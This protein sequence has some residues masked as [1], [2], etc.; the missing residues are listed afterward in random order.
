[1][2]NDIQKALTPT[3]DDLL[4]DTRLGR[5]FSKTNRHCALQ[6]WI[7][8]LKSGQSIENR[9]IYGRLLPYSYSNNRWSA[10]DDD[11]FQTYDQVRAQVI[12]L[13]LYIQSTI[14]P[15]LLRL[16]SAGR[17]IS[18]ISEELKLGLT[19]KL[20][21]RFGMTSLN[22]ERLVYRP[23]AY[24]LNRDAHEQHS[25][26]SPHGG[27]GVFSASITQVDKGALFHLGHGY[28]S[29][30]TDAVIKHLN[31]CTGL[32]FS[33]A[34]LT[35]LGDI[36][37][38]VFPALDDLERSL[39]SVSW[40][41]DSSAFVARFNPQQV[42]EFC[43]FQFR[44]SITN[45]DQ[46]AYAE[47]A[48][49]GRDDDGVFECR[50]EIGEQLRAR[51]DATELE[52]FGYESK[53]S[54]HSTLCC[55]WRMGYVREIN[56]QGRAVGQGG[57][58]VKFDWLEKTT[59]PTAAAR[60]RAVLTMH[61]DN[62]DFASCIGGRGADP[63][64]RVNQDF[65][66]IFKRLHPPKSEGQFFQRWGVGEGD[67][68][69]QF[70]EWFRSLLSKYGQHQIV[71]FDPYFEDAGL[72]LLLLG[73]MPDADYIVFTSLP[74][75]SEN[76]E[77]RCE[78]VDRPTSGRINNLLASC[79]RN[80]HL[81]KRTKLRVYGM[82][83][84]RLHD[85]Y[86]LVMAPDG[87]PVAGFNL[88][89]S[90]QSAAQNYPL[91]ITPI[92]A[93]TLLK[94]EHYVAELLKDADAE[95]LE[96][97]A[98]TTPLQ[99][100]FDAS[101]SAI[102]P[103]RHE[104]LQFLEKAQSG[105]VLAGWVCAPSLRT[106]CGDSLKEKMAALGL[107]K[108]ESLSLPEARSLRD[109]LAQQAGDFTDFLSTWEILG[110]L[111]A[112]TPSGDQ[113]FPELR[114]DRGFLEFLVLYLKAS[115]SRAYD[116]AD[117]ELAVMSPQIF[118]MSLDALLHSSY[119]TDQLFHATKYVALTWADYFAIRFLWW[120]DPSALLLLAE[121]QM[122]SVPQ[123]LQ[124][125][126][127][128][129]LSLLGQVIAEVSLAIEFGID[130][131]QRDSL[132]RSKNNLLQWMGLCAIERALK[133]SGDINAAVELIAVFPCS[134]HISV[135]GWMIHRTAENPKTA[136][137]FHGL[138]ASLHRSLPTPIPRAEL[139]NT[140]YAMRGHMHQLGWAGPW[141]FLDVV[142]PLLQNGRVTADD[143]CEIWFQELSELL[144]PEFS[145]QLHQFD[146][147][148]EGQTTN[149]TA[150]LFAY[151]G[152][153][154]QLASL[155]S[156]KAIL[157]RQQRIVQQPLA[158][159]TD[160]SRWDDAL[161]VSLWTLTFIRWSQ[162]YLADGS[163]VRHELDALSRDAEK[164]VAFRSMDEWRSQRVG[165]QSELV[166]FLDQAEELLKGPLE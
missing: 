121:E 160:W 75:P 161:I 57:A 113:N 83:N 29:A 56:I 58:A 126:D 148:R 14:C 124:A 115:F 155:A 165:R 69:L 132:V 4:G 60:L 71:I 110:D 64:V 40:A 8:Q 73:G 65:S 16:L 21:A 137:I 146:R 12:Q 93:D 43:G 141:L 38:M 18:A 162:H 102:V 53:Q 31:S 136:E 114:S 41:N 143:A 99:L 32:D 134:A 130:D 87:L 135:L 66:T 158:S 128:V 45:G 82:K 74:K 55:R 164:L 27:A 122:S 6:F 67:G 91:L 142:L 107:L 19:K 89:N 39:M 138:I 123:E 47:I 98:D 44:L 94:V 112:H 36:E 90:F 78:G 5:L 100:L 35:R 125:V 145:Q 20:D 116:A 48:I 129:R 68:R 154:R 85:R 37:L 25:L 105:D 79:E 147:S 76:N 156:L 150:F 157:K 95:Q 33:G 46:I 101:A 153:E 106:L 117:N 50:F 63:W 24:L 151:S 30:L 70:V 88:S 17:T 54:N 166:V 97:E 51:V 34:D 52:I 2:R 163:A 149:T 152:I 84:G 11:V 59:R 61:R 26:S 139:R 120:Y 133:Q 62:L 140:I 92:P 1:M 104:P 42:P 103:R 22:A 3:L 127:A 81:M 86:I 109:F 159:T 15:K 119:R 77:P 131:E 7:L 23:V 72:G 13:N 108:G 49:A 80:R 111:L 9:V 28:D 118:Q 144:E 96:V 10:S